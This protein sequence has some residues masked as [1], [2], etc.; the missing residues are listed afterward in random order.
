MVTK[1]RENLAHSHELIGADVWAVGEPKVHEE[2]LALEVLIG[3]ILK[4]GESG[5]G[6]SVMLGKGDAL[7]D[8]RRGCCAACSRCGRRENFTSI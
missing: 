8:V 4:Y 7:E 3:H 5:M 2:P 1:R 6:R